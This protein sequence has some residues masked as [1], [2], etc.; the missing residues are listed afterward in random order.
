MNTQGRQCTERSKGG[1]PGVSIN[2]GCQEPR[3]ADSEGVQLWWFGTSSPTTADWIFV[4]FMTLKKFTS[5]G[6]GRK[7]IQSLNSKYFQ[8]Y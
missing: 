4:D 5:Y 3:E 2:Q 1:S 8:F 6:G 7:L